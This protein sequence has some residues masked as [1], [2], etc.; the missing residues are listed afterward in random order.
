MISAKSGHDSWIIKHCCWSI[1]YH[2]SFIHGKGDSLS[3]WSAEVTW[4]WRSLSDDW[5]IQNGCWS[6]TYHFSFI[7]GKGDLWS[8]WSTQVT[9][10]SRLE[11][12]KKNEHS[13]CVEASPTCLH[14]LSSKGRFHHLHCRRP[15]RRHRRRL[16]TKTM[17]RQ[18]H[19][20][21][22]SW[23]LDSRKPNVGPMGYH[24]FYNDSF[25]ARA[26]HDLIDQPKS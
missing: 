9:L 11:Q 18:G 13:Q 20:R 19:L 25:M 15:H 7:H 23:S 4:I 14:R 8:H 17:V 1:I 21:S 12:W 26:I 24:F 6:I 16:A 22:S 3:H 2:F 10:I 5:I